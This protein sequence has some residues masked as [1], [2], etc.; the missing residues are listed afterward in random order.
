MALPVSYII[1]HAERILGIPPYKAAGGLN[2]HLGE[3][4]EVDEARA[5]IETWLGEELP[6]LPPPPLDVVSTGSLRAAVAT[7]GAL[8]TTG[9]RAADLRVVVASM[10]LYGWNGAEWVLVGGAG[11]GA[12]GGGL[13]ATQLMA[14]AL[15][16]AGRV[17]GDLHVS[18]YGAPSAGAVFLWSDGGLGAVTPTT[19][20]TRSFIDYLDGFTVTYRP[21]YVTPTDQGSWATRAG[22]AP[23]TDAAAM[24]LVTRVPEARS[25]NMARNAYI[26]SDAELAAF[27]AAASSNPYNVFVTG[28]PGIAQPSTDELIQWVSHKWGLPTDLVRAQ[29]HLESRW[30]MDFLGDRVTQPDSSH[31]NAAPAYA[32]VSPGLD[33]YESL[34]ISQLRWFPDKPGNA[35]PHPG[36]DPLRWRSTAFNLDYYG[37]TVRG[38]YDDPGGWRSAWGV[39]GDTY[40]PGDQWKSVGSWFSPLPWSGNG[41]ADTYIAGVQQRLIDRPWTV[42]DFT[43]V[44]ADVVVVR[45]P[46]ITRSVSG[47]VT[48]RPRPVIEPYVA[49]ALPGVPQ[50]V[51]ATAG[52]ATVTLGWDAPASDGGAPLTGYVLTEAD[53]GWSVATGS[54]AAGPYTLTALTNGR[55]YRFTLAAINSVGTGPASAATGLVTPAA[56]AGFS[57]PPAMPLV[58]EGVLVKTSNE[59]FRPATNLATPMRPAPVTR[60]L[61]TWRSVY[62]PTTLAPQWGA[63]HVSEIPG[64]SAI[65]LHLMGMGQPR[66]DPAGQLGSVAGSPYTTLMRDYKVQAHASVNTAIPADGDAGW[67]DLATVT[68]NRRTWRVHG[69]LDL[70]A[71]GWLRVRVTASNGAPGNDDLA[72]RMEL[73]DASNGMGNTIL[74][75]G[76]SISMETSGLI[77][78]ATDVWADGG[79]AEAI[80]QAA[81]RDRPLLTDHSTG[82]WSASIGNANKAAYLAGMPHKIWIIGFGHNDAHGAN[83]DLTAGGGATSAYA[84]QYK[85]DMQAIIDYALTQGAQRVVIPYIT[86]TTNGSFDEPNTV[87]LN[88]I[89]DQ[90]VAANADTVQLGPDMH[91]YYQAHASEL[92]DGIHPTIQAGYLSH[93]TLWANWFAANVYA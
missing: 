58:S 13:S 8:P 87:F 21:H 51:T 40:A 27:H 22:F 4:L 14:E 15:L 12:A 91:A 42:A 81:G 65:A 78:A 63:I 28:R 64:R 59:D 62:V 19:V 31:Y 48:A 90:L 39:P 67:V 17:V 79:L 61:L 25:V 36:T 70:A 86:Y 75:Y 84:L 6:D 46:E 45:Q 69:P 93:H 26:P 35:N 11:G 76:D 18:T 72:F 54:A 30:S 73:F 2:E 49:P 56:P 34:G 50:N 41:P 38:Y 60:D 47:L 23:L 74:L 29:M 7:V 57:P 66:F 83:V 44:A 68:D 20:N 9:N 77:D 33:V 82:G 24:A 10:A 1:D 92:R 53:E 32:R 80:G 43:D 3:Q 89:I 55:S 88:Q 5:I 16:G 71:Y 52:N 85:A 37:A